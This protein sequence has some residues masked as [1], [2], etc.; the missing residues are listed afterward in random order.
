MTDTHDSEDWR[1]QCDAHKALGDDAF[2]AAQYPDAIRHYT[3]ALCLDPTN[4]VLLSNRSAARL[5]QGESSKAFHDATACVKAAPAEFTKGYSR[6]GAALQALK[7]WKPAKEAYQ[8]VL[9]VDPNNAAAKQGLQ[10]CNNRLKEQEPTPTQ[11]TP[12]PKTEEKDLLDDFFD[13]VET[14][15]TITTETT[16]SDSTTTPTTTT[17]SLLQ[18]QT[19]HVGTASSQIDRLMA[20][21]FKWRNLNPFTVLDIPPTATTDDISRRYKALS[22]LLHPDKC[23]AVPFAQEAYDQV[24]RSKQQLDDEDKR[25]HVCALMEEGRKMGAALF[26]RDKSMTLEEFQT[27]ETHR[28][29][30]QV[31]MKRT[32]VEKRERNYERRERDHEESEL[33]KE[34]KERAFDKS[35]R[36]ED[37]V[38]KRVGNWRD[39]EKQANKKMKP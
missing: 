19:K 38:G 18:I 27:R 39:F 28:I 15:T 8:H 16:N 5:H 9:N 17:P 4:H 24:Q 26:Q 1:V 3:T 6:L 34:K 10:D 36:Q 35:W 2:R 11:S 30:A 20:P 25:R 32:E 7:R 13:E 22:L 23:A 37:R 31:E 29:F 21:N 14:T 12:I 33:Q